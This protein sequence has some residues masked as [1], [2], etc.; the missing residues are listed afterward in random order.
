[1]EFEG[2]LRDLAHGMSNVQFLGR[3]QPSELAQLYRDAIALL[4]PAM[5]YETFGFI[6]L[7]ALGQRTPVIAR[8]LGAV[9]EVVRDTGG[10]IT[11]QTEDELLEAMHLLQSDRS[12]RDR[13]ASTGYDSYV[14]RY[15]ESQHIESYLDALMTAAAAQRPANWQL[16]RG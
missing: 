11:Y 9:A 16:G 10:G 8:E 6:T 3:K 5:V 13:L 2:D 12:L 7:E 14:S 4:V 1:G 15:S